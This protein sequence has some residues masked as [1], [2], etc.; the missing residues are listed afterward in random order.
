MESSRTISL[1][2]PFQKANQLNSDLDTGHDYLPGYPRIKLSDQECLYNF[3]SQEL[4]ANDLEKIA[5]RLW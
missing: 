4:W 3:I 2:Y 5:N 1:Q